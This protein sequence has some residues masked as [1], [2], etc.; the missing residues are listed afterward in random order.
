[1]KLV[2][3]SWLRLTICWPAA[4]ARSRRVTCSRS[5]GSRRVDEFIQEATESAISHVAIVIREKA[6]GAAFAAGGDGH[7]GHRDA[8]RRGARGLP[9]RTTPASICRSRRP[10][11]ALVVPA[12]LADYYASNAL[13]KY[14]YDGVVEAGLYDLDH[15]LV[16]SAAHATS[17][18]NSPVAR[19]ARWWD[20]LIERGAQDL[21]EGV[22]RDARLPA[23]LLLAAGLRGAPGDEGRR[24]S[25]PRAA[26]G[27]GR[28]LLVRHLRRRLPAQRR[29]RSC[30]TPSAGATRR[31][32][33]PRRAR[34]PRRTPASS[35]P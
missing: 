13:D 33:W 11:R 29:R 34:P 12:T 9:G 27:P 4:A 8:A 2:T 20:R 30:R 14:N 23:A 3:Q 15:P 7:G 35:R 22:R 16:R 24:R 28:G 25:R 31:P 6:G 10:S 18:S 19:I 21:G 32:R 17:T 5:T 26:G 1:M